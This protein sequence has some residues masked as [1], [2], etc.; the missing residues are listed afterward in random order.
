MLLGFRFFWLHDII[1]Y[2]NNNRICFKDKT[3]WI[4]VFT[5][6]IFFIISCSPSTLSFFKMFLLIDIFYYLSFISYSCSSFTLS[7]NSSILLYCT[8][9]SFQ[10]FLKT[11]SFF[12]NSLFK[13]SMLDF[14]LTF[15]GSYFSSILE[16]SKSFYFYTLV[17]FSLIFLNSSFCYITSSSFFISL[18]SYYFCTYFYLLRQLSRLSISCFRNLV[19]QA[20]FVAISNCDFSYLST[21]YLL[22]P[23]SSLYFCSRNLCS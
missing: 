23:I 4:L 19:I 21:F 2:L 9:L 10:F 18:C 11:N 13:L 20:S 15:S 5:S 8:F 22:N 17:N 16:T 12:P 7:C 6:L 1:E 14:K 3:Q